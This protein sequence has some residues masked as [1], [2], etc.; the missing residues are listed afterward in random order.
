MFAPTRHTYFVVEQGLRDSQCT[1]FAN[2]KGSGPINDDIQLRKWFICCLCK[3][4]GEHSKCIS[5][6]ALKS[7]PANDPISRM[8]AEYVVPMG[9]PSAYVVHILVPK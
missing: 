4:T 8:D 9:I 6:P 7:Y 2:H 1:V 5:S 3:L